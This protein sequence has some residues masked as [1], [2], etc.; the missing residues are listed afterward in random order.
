MEAVTGT[1]TGKHDYQLQREMNNVFKDN[2]MEAYSSFERRRGKV[3]LV[4]KESE[5][6]KA[7]ALFLERHP[8]FQFRE[9]TQQTSF[10]ETT[11]FITFFQL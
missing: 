3:K 11:Y 9:Q 5:I 6:E 10:G 7:K 8:D 2:D 1:L 4:C